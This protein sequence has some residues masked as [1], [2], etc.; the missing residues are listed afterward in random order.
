MPTAMRPSGAG[1][2]PNNQC[3][4]R[5]HIIFHMKILVALDGSANGLRVAKYVSRVAS[6]QDWDITLYHVLQV[7]AALG[8]HGGSENP[9]REV[10]LESDL[11][12]ETEKWQDQKR[13]SAIKKYSNPHLNSSSKKKRAAVG[14][15]LRC[16]LTSKEIRAWTSFK[17]SGL[18]DTTPWFSAAAGTRH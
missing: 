7:P 17:G 9:E 5:Q 12:A 18:K 14:F 8:E 11:D 10:Q 6:R 4:P 16:P 1:N 3:G 13:I 2:F 15:K